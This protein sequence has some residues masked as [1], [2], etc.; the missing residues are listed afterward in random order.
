MQE[1]WLV[2]FKHLWEETILYKTQAISNPIS[3]KHIINKAETFISKAIK[4]FRFTALFKNML[5]MKFKTQLTYA[6]L[7]AIN[8]ISGPLGKQ[9]FT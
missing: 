4:L 7:A 1:I 9:N 3:M 5:T 8:H 2:L 6:F